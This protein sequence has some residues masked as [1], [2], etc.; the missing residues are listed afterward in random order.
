MERYVYRCMIAVAMLGTPALIMPMGHYS[1]DEEAVGEECAICF[2]TRAPEQFKK[3]VGCPHSFCIPCLTR[4]AASNYNKECSLCRH[5]WTDQ[6]YNFLGLGPTPVNRFSAQSKQSNAPLYIGVAVITAAVA[7]TAYG[8]Y[9]LYQYITKP[10]S[11][12][13][14]DL[15]TAIVDLHKEAIR[16]KNRAQN[17][18][19]LKDTVKKYYIEQLEKGAFAALTPKNAMLL[20]ARVDAF[21]DALNNQGAIDQEYAALVQVIA[22][23]LQQADKPAQVASATPMVAPVAAVQVKQTSTK[24]PAI[25]RPA[26][27]KRVK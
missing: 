18:V 21:D 10:K 16:C 19:Y 7:G 11:A 15:K 26:R 17:G 4:I 13:Q 27:T 6:D 24:K 3:L 20:A 1:S 14:K 12:V 8:C 23:F 2:H 9:T 22:D 25:K 5:P